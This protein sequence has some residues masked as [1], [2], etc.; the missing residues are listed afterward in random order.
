MQV[1]TEITS[2]YAFEAWSGAVYTKTK[3]MENGIDEDF[4]SFA[5]ELFPDGCTDMDLNDLLW[6][7]SDMIFEHFG[8]DEC[9]NPVE[10]ADDEDTE[11]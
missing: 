9:G 3:L 10:N 11:D 2:L 7:E 4:I 8:L 6:F 5:E 1:T